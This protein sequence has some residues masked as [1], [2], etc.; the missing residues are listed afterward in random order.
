[1][2]LQCAYYSDGTLPHSSLQ[3]ARRKAGINTLR[4]VCF[5]TLAITCGVGMPLTAQTAHF[6]GAMKTLAS[7]SSFNQPWGVAVDSSGNVY[8]ADTA[9]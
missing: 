7:G 3:T 8:V 9:R 1:M 2:T 4:L 6:G 5:A